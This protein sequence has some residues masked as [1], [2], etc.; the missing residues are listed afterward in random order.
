MDLKGEAKLC[1]IIR[2]IKKYIQ[3]LECDPCSKLHIIINN[4]DLI[5]PG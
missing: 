1:G 4:I 5:V 3:G 2:G